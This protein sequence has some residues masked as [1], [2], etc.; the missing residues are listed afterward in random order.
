MEPF[1]RTLN[2]ETIVRLGTQKNE[3]ALKTL[4]DLWS[5]PF[6]RNGIEDWGSESA[7]QYHG[8]PQNQLQLDVQE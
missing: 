4:E 8:P 3:A 5:K 2:P 7:C 1:N 6:A